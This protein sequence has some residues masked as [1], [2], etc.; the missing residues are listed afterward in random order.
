[1]QRVVVTGI[2]I[3]A[4]AG[5]GK[6]LFWRNTLAGTSYIERDEEMRAIGTKSNVLSRVRCFDPNQFFTEADDHFL[7]NEDRFI[8]FGVA[9]GKLAIEDA[10]L[11]LEE[12]DADEIGIITSTAIGG[13]P[14]VSAA[15]ERFTGRGT[16][17]FRYESFGAQ[18]HHAT[19]SNFPS[20]VLMRKYGLRGMSVALSTGCTAGIDAVGLSFDV[21][22][23][24]AAQVMI[25]GAS[26]APLAPISYATLDV[27][28]A[29]SVFEGDPAK[30]SRP[31]DA[32]RAG[33]V[34]GEG[35]GMLVLESLDHAL[36]RRAHIYA[37][38]LSFASGSN[39]FHMSDLP[40][41]GKPMI[42]VLRAA[43]A[44]A[45]L[46]PYQID[47]INAHGSST[48]Q[49]DVFETASYREVFG[50]HATTIPISSTK[51]MVGHSLSAASVTGAI[52]ALGAIELSK[53][54]PTINYEFPDEAC[55]LDYVTDG[56]REAIVRNAMVTASGF[57]GIHSVAI[58]QKPE[59]TSA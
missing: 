7:L 54:H 13:T 40:G 24:G 26:E 30:A 32:K 15:W 47:Y 51:S 43:L 45:K 46:A 42:K 56:A 36:A 39:A 59:V 8:Q 31:F 58:F 44:Q 6:D 23:S 17:P 34:L 55:D 38:M 16:R 1:M 29:L 37:E 10:D 53:I 28:G 22:R 12:E 50:E 33:F 20:A 18:L 21:I 41:D 27:I 5:V 49:N 11:Q 35:A 57:G 14:T 52:A 9:A 19:C 3:V 4:P 48:P 25:A 2:G